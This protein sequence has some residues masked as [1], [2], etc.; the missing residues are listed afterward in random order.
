MGGE[1]IW[2]ETLASISRR[3]LRSAFFV[4]ESSDLLFS[5]S[6]VI[7]N[8]RS[9]LT[10]AKTLA[11]LTRFIHE[12]RHTPHESSVVRSRTELNVL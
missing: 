3:L 5:A 9:E 2:L 10:G 8:S 12:S 4:S 11:G 7:S 1:E 6:E